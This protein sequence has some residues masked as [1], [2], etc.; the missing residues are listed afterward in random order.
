MQAFNVIIL[1][2]A[3]ILMLFQGALNKNFYLFFILSLPTSIIGTQI[4]IFLFKYLSD[5]FYKRLVLLLSIFSVG[6]FLFNQNF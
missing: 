3:F 2:M 4:G 6:I 1:G 5:Y